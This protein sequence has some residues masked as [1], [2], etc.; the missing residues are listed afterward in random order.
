MVEAERVLLFLKS[1]TC[2]EMC[3]K[4]GV[5]ERSL[6]RAE[7]PSS[8]KDNLIEY[9]ADI[10]KFVSSEEYKISTKIFVCLFPTISRDENNQVTQAIWLLINV[11]GFGGDKN[12]L[13]SFHQTQ[14]LD[15][16]P[17]VGVA[18]ATG[19]R[20][21]ACCGRWV[22]E[23]DDND[24]S[25]TFNSIS[26][27]FKQPFIVDPSF[28]LDISTGQIFCFLPT[29]LKSKFP[30]HLHGYFSLSSNRRALAWPAHDNES[31]VGAKWNF[32]LSKCIG[33]IAYSVFLF[34]CTKALKHPSPLDY[35]YQLLSCWSA[36][37]PDNTL[38][39]TIL[40]G[41][42]HRLSNHL[43]LYCEQGGGK[44]ISV[45]DGVF[46]P[47]MLGETLVHEDTC[48]NLLQT[49]DQ[50]VI[51]IPGFIREIV[52][53]LPKFKS[54]IISRKITPILIRNLLRDNWGSE[55][56]QRYLSSRDNSVALL[57]VVLS[58]LS[59]NDSPKRVLS[60]LEG[61]PLLLTSGCELPKAFSCNARG[62]FISSN[63]PALL[64]IFPGLEN[65]FVDPFLPRSIHTVLLSLASRVDRLNI[66]D[67][68][69]LHNNA[70]MFSH[71]LQKCM[72]S[73]FSIDTNITSVIWTPLQNNQPPAEWI[74]SLFEFIGSSKPILSAISHLPI[75]PQGLLTDDVITLL[76]LKS[77]IIYI[78]V[79]GN[80]SM[81][82]LENLL[83]VSGCFL[84]H[85]HTFIQGY[86]NFVLPPVP[87]GLFTALNSPHILDS[88]ITA[89]EE[90][91]EKLKFELIEL[92]IPLINKQNIHLV[93]QLPL[94]PNSSSEWLRINPGVILPPL[95]LPSDIQYPS[96]ILTPSNPNVYRFC[97]KLRIFPDSKDSFI[98]MHLVPFLISLTDPVSR[99][100]LT[101]WILDNVKD[102]NNSSH[103]Y[104][105][106][107][108][109]LLDSSGSE[110][111]SLY[112]PFQLLDPR[113]QLL[114]MILPT[115]SIGYFP[116]QLYE[117][118]L[119]IM[120]K[121]L[122]L[123]TRDNLTL[124]LCLRICRSCVL[125]LQTVTGEEWSVT[126]RAILTLLSTHLGTFDNTSL[127]K[128]W[129]IFITASFIIPDANPPVN[130]PMCL[131]FC[132]SDGFYP[133]QNILV[134][135][136]L[137][138]YLVGSVRY[139]LV[140]PD[141]L[142]Q[143][144]YR[145]VILNM[146]FCTT[147]H[148]DIVIEQL[149]FIS[150]T[151]ILSKHETASIHEMVC[152]IYSFLDEKLFT[153]DSII[154]NFIFI[155]GE[156][157]FVS[158]EQVVTKTPFDTTPYL[159]SLHDLNYSSNTLF[160][161][162]KINRYPTITQLC[163]ILTIL[164]LSD[165]LL[166][167]TQLDLVTN[168]LTYLIRQTTSTTGLQVYVPGKDLK[169]YKPQ[170][171]ELVFCDQSWL[172]RS[173]I[174][175]EFIFVHER[176]PNDTAYKL[177]VF[178]FSEKVALPSEV[179]FEESG[180][181]ILLTDRIRG[182]LDSYHGNINVLKEML[183][184]AD[185]AKATELNVIF[186]MR[187]H[188]TNSL[189]SA[190]LQDWQGPAI[191]FHN[192]STFKDSDFND[193][194]RIEGAT[195]MQDKTTIGRFGLG[196]CTTYHLTDLPSFV[197][198]SYIHI[199][200][201]HKR[202][203]GHQRGGVKIDFCQGRYAKYI[204]LYEDQFAPY[205]DM[206]G[207]DV[208][209]LSPF[210]GTL[211]RLPFR[212]KNIS[213]K[214][215]LSAYDSDG[216]VQLQESFIR[217]AETLLFFTQHVNS[218]GIYVINPNDTPQHMNLIHSVRRK[219]VSSPLSIQPFLQTHQQLIE[220][221]LNGSSE[222]AAVSTCRYQLSVTHKADTNWIVS[223]ATGSGACVEVLKKFIR[224]H[225]PPPFAGV[226]YNSDLAAQ[227]P[228]KG[229]Q[230]NLY[231]FL[232]LPI[233]IGLPFHCHAMFEL[234]SDRQGLVEVAEA[235]TEWN[236]VVVSDALVSA[237]LE[238]YQQLADEVR[239]SENENNY[240]TYLSL[241][242]NAFSKDMVNDSLWTGFTQTFSRLIERL[243]EIFLSDSR[244]GYVWGSFIDVSFLNI[245]S[246]ETE[247]REFYS[248][249][250]VTK[251]RSVLVRSGY[252]VAV[253]PESSYK[254]SGLLQYILEH[255][256]SNIINLTRFASIFFANLTEHDVS[257]I[258]YILNI[259]ISACGPYPWLQDMLRSS[260]CIPCGDMDT[261]QAPGNVVD[262]NNRIIAQLYEYSENRIP[263]EL[264]NQKLFK[265]PSPSLTN[266]KKYLHILSF[267]LPETELV[268]R[269]EYI[270][271]N[272]NHG[273]A[274]NFIEYLDQKSFTG[275]EIEEMYSCLKN[276]PFI[277]VECFINYI[278]DVKLEFIA[279]SQII[280]NSLKQLVEFQYPVVPEWMMKYTNFLVYMKVSENSLHLDLPMIAIAE[281]DICIR[282]SEIMQ[283]II[284]MNSKI[285]KIYQTVGKY[286]STD[287]SQ[288]SQI[289]TNCFWIPSVGFCDVT[290][291]VLSSSEDFSPYIHSLN[292]Y[293]E[294]N[295]STGLYSFFH[296]LR[297]SK[298]LSSTQCQLVMEELS[299]ESK[300][301]ALTAQEQRIT[302]RLIQ[303]LS[304]CD[305]S[306]T[307]MMMLGID[308]RIHLAR[309]C[310]FHDLCW[311]KR[312]YSAGVVTHRQSTYHFIHKEVSHDN[313]SSLG[314]K[315][316]SD[317]TLSTRAALPFEYKSG[318]QSEPLTTRLRSILRDYESDVDVFKELVQN[319]DDAK[320][321]EVKFL[322]DFS[323][324]GSESLITEK[325]KCWQG[326]AIYC[327]NNSTFSDSDF[328]NITKL[329][330]RSKISDTTTIGTFGIGFNTVYHF[331]D[332]PSFVSR[333][334][335]HIFDPHVKYLEGLVPCDRPGMSVNFVEACDDLKVFNDQFSVYNGVFG[336]DIFSKR[337]YGHTLFR[338]PLRT[339]NVSS[340]ISQKYYDTQESIQTL[341]N[342]FIEIAKNLIIFLQNI[343]SIELYERSALN[344][345]VQLVY[346]VTKG[347]KPIRFL[348]D[349]ETHFNRLLSGFTQEPVTQ[350]ECI[351]LT[352]QD[353]S[354][355]LTASEEVLI[356]YSSGIEQCCS[357]ARE[358]R[359]QHEISAK[360]LCSVAIP[361]HFIDLSNED[362]SK[363]KCYLF[364]FLPIPCFSGYPMHINGT[365]QLQ[366]SR[367]ALHSTADANIR[368]RWNQTLITEALSIALVNA[369]VYLTKI[370][371]KQ[372]PHTF[373]QDKLTRYYSFWPDS[374]QNELLWANYSTSV[375]MRIIESKS[376][377]FH[378]TLH[379]ERWV[380]ID[381]VVFFESPK[382]YD[383]EP[384][385]IKF[386][387]SF[388]SECFI[389]FID[390]CP[391]FESHP[392]IQTI[393]QKL[394]HKLYSLR[395]VCEEVIWVNF[396]YFMNSE[397]LSL[398]LILST[399]LPVI[400]HEPWLK[401]QFLNQPC[402]PCGDV[403][404]ILRMIPS[405]VSP[406]SVFSPI[407]YPEDKVIPHNYF[408]SLF[409]DFEY[410]QALEQLNVI[411][412]KLPPHILVERCN[413]ALEISH[414]DQ[415]QA[416]KH[417]NCILDYLNTFRYLTPEIKLILD[418]LMNIPFIPVHQDEVYNVICPGT[419]VFL[420]APSNCYEF[421]R[422]MYLTPEL[423]AVTQETN[424]LRSAMSLLDI[425]DKE[426]PLKVLLDVILNF[427]RNEAN[428]CNFE[429]SR[430]SERMEAVYLLIANKCFLSQG[431][432]DNATVK[433]NRELV[434][435][436]LKGVSWIWHQAFCKFFPVNQIYLSDE[437]L[438][439]R[440]RYLIHFPYPQLIEKQ[441]VDKFFQF[442]G[443]SYKVTAENAVNIISRM[444]NDF[445]EFPL[446]LRN[447]PKEP[448]ECGLVIHLINSLA[449]E[450]DERELYHD[451]YILTENCNLKLASQLHSN[452]MPWCDFGEDDR[453]TLVHSKIT[454][455]A[456][457]KLG[458]KSKMETMYQIKWTNFGQHE[459]LTN[460]IEGL[461]REFPCDV[462]IFKEL[463]QNAEDA[464]ATEVVFVLDSRRYGE[465]TLCLSPNLQKNWK[466]LQRIPSLL[467]YNNRPFS[468]QDFAGIQ[469]VGIGGKRGKS[470]IGRF[471]LGFNSVYHLTRCPCLFVGS[472][473]G[474]TSTFCVFDPYKEH[475]NIPDGKLPGFKLEADTSNLAMFEDQLTPYLQETICSRFQDVFQN[476]RENRS[477]SMF[478]LP[479]NSIKENGLNIDDNV[480]LTKKLLEDLI[481]EAPR[482]FPFIKNLKN[483]QIY[484]VTEGNVV[485]NAIISSQILQ[486]RH[487]T[488][489]R[490]L[491]G[492]KDEIEVI[493][494]KI[495]VKELVLGIEGKFA[496]FTREVEWLIYHFNGDVNTFFKKSKVLKKYKSVYQREKLV[497]FS[498]IAVEIVCEDFPNPS[499]S[500]YLFCHLPFGNALDFPVHVNAPF[501]LDANRRYVSYQ[502]QLTGENSW[503]NIWHTEI[504]KLILTPLYFQLLLDLGSGGQ[505]HCN[506]S[507][508]K[509]YVWYYKLFPVI[510]NTDQASNSIEFLQ[511]L[512][513]GVL[514]LLY[515][516]NSKIL[517]ADD[518][519]QIEPRVWFPIQG[520]AAGI[521]KAPDSF[522]NR[523]L[524]SDELYSCLVK[525]RYPLTAAP[526]VIAQSLRAS[527]PGETGKSRCKCV[528]PPDV[529]NFMNFQLENFSQG[530]GSVFPCPM[531]K[532]VLSFEEIC[533]LLTYVFKHFDE[534]NIVSGSLPLKVDCSN[535]L[536]KFKISKTSTFT[537]TYS[538]LLPH[539]KGR[540]LSERYPPDIVTK[541][542][543]YG[544][545]EKMNAQF[546]SKKLK[547]PFPVT[548]EFFLLF[549]NFI[550]NE[551]HDYQ[552]F[553]TLFGHF[554]LVSIQY[555]RDIS[556][557]PIFF[558]IDQLKYI[559]TD[560]ISGAHRS[561][562]VNLNCPFLC[563][564]ML[565]E[566]EESPD[567]EIRNVMAIRNLIQRLA[568]TSTAAVQTIKCISL[569]KNK[570][571]VLLDE[572][573]VLLRKLLPSVECTDLNGEDYES[574]SHLRIFMSES[575]HEP[576]QYQQIA[577]DDYNMYFMDNT[578]PYCQELYSLLRERYGLVSLSADLHNNNPIT[579]I[580]YICGRIGKQLLPITTVIQEYILNTEIF[581]QMCFQEQ[582]RIIDY[583]S[584]RID[585]ESGL[586]KLE[587]I[588][589]IYLKEVE[590]FYFKP[591]N[592]FSPHI[593]FFST[594]QN[595]YL[596][597]VE[598]AKAN[599]LYDTMLNLGL[600]TT[601][602]LPFITEAAVAVAED[603]MNMYV[604]EQIILLFTT[605]R[606]CLSE[607]L[608]N[609]IT[610]SDILCLQQLSQIPF[611]PMYTVR[612]F[613]P[614]E[615]DTDCDWRL[616]YFHEAQMSKHSNYCCAVSPI[617]HSSI[618]FTPP[619]IDQRNLFHDIMEL[620]KIKLEPDILE[621]KGN[622][623][624]LIR[625]FNDYEKHQ[626]ADFVKQYF[627][628]TYAYLEKYCEDLSEFENA[629]CILYRSQ[630]YEP[631]N[632]V[633]KKMKYTYFPYLFQCQRE[634]F[635]YTKVLVLLK[636]K[637]YPNFASFNLVLT[638]IKNIIGDGNLD[639][640]SQEKRTIA[641]RAFSSLIKELREITEEEETV[642]M[643][644]DP[645]FWML[646]TYDELI[647]HDSPDLYY[648]DDHSLLHCVS[649]CVSVRIHVLAPL[650]WEKLHS[651]APPSCLRMK[652]LTSRFNQHL[653]PDVYQKYLV[654]DDDLEARFR[655]RIRDPF[656]L[657][658]L[659]RIYY[660]FMSDEADTP[661]YQTIQEKLSKLKIIAVDKIVIV[662]TDERDYQIP[663]SEDLICFLDKN[664][665]TILFKE[666][667]NCRECVPVEV[668]VVLNQYFERMFDK[669]L[670]YLEICLVY[671]PEQVSAILDS[672]NIRPHHSP[673]DAD[674]QD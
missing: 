207:C 572:E 95:N 91:D 482:L 584:S 235:K 323:T 10:N 290:R 11:I 216:I 188:P 136:P 585:R 59:S 172:N 398:K 378:C 437:Y 337:E 369:L 359:E 138:L 546:L 191:L 96:H 145:K 371:S 262:P 493:T 571:A 624:A 467:V 215:S 616:G 582:I 71:L 326:P 352:T 107:A 390:I 472:E 127:V 267:K 113:D 134:C 253:I 265:D 468:Q 60:F 121:F 23:W 355:D 644:A 638:C 450:L 2:I 221:I 246:F 530:S 112:S 393:Y 478:R 354:V 431:I 342:E 299:L 473:D 379:P 47:S 412:T 458:A 591:S 151:E 613:V 389:Y 73:L 539:L 211:F 661:P 532:C 85:K 99:N 619:P 53:S 336:C 35:H 386:I 9:R 499:Q 297:V 26:E 396:P 403:D 462:T 146:G 363:I 573:A 171:E 258:L 600:N 300:D 361:T 395:R 29:Q 439:Y 346:R 524:Y 564:P 231:C 120:K 423:H 100:K 415:Q 49:F 289:P 459:D 159:Y 544:Y 345:D 505:R 674:V 508:E 117:D 557:Q 521:F 135:R 79:S 140:L 576:S 175:E 245:T 7:V 169:L 308:N 525:L 372:Y 276:T 318:G 645:Q 575:E 160:E 243:P 54:Q 291:L 606:D 481:Q 201:P 581:P 663:N 302:L 157:K 209:S 128:I 162:M 108:K 199:L 531:D 247:L 182:I 154:P 668:T 229:Y 433:E 553:E 311:D 596:L 429:D 236:R 641:K 491:A 455:L 344:R 41:G 44:W 456:S 261:L 451:V 651:S 92:F 24:S 195:K 506:I 630:L 622:L 479:L 249:D 353:V 51:F 465:E 612:N 457:H 132:K 63:T 404:P 471:G 105:M 494:K 156:C 177:G 131:P 14:H 556:E 264:C 388:A 350:V 498:S 489:M 19:V 241:L 50:P 143:A 65:D 168:I 61:V 602:T 185:D 141:L 187:Y 438:Q 375:C 367:R 523:L 217:E 260:L 490:P 223:F 631:Q 333:N 101:T 144:S 294:I 214:I 192:N 180:Q 184:N 611:I 98:H 409:E 434:K 335:L 348:S 655:T 501:I 155:P 80:E 416:L 444:K 515:D 492:Y 298:S 252:L 526:F 36:H 411:T 485:C 272:S 242:F 174:E 356:S 202:Y 442:M 42:L 603:R 152:G 565:D 368:T 470:T 237:A 587:Q 550:V 239:C 547:V 268:A 667:P 304:S 658:A 538:G 543:S 514:N 405:V 660:H 420:S 343:E 500:K 325:M 263:T 464:G 608:I 664:E 555:G 142:D 122:R 387:F 206:F 502:D 454:L 421:S 401:L 224:G 484:E 332:L 659:V 234:R 586:C 673:S 93:K 97:E 487:S 39:S 77:S 270:H 126:F 124:D 512:G 578:F 648:S 397:I 228:T 653:S 522:H 255:D 330:A 654:K 428:L 377:V 27:I 385:L 328:V 273:L 205:K 57:E 67:V 70:R 208:R 627:D 414:R 58:A 166:S 8:F 281:L 417:V 102:L 266:L 635:P 133:P 306:E 511:L 365:F 486:Q 271:E 649:Q 74:I 461:L 632:I 319:S 21:V 621:V 574:L 570:R 38:F 109:W 626:I 197:S 106:K 598:W 278:G 639:F 527:L 633:L 516:T 317:V 279:P 189:L 83:E 364:C 194:M 312:D 75:L 190:S 130:W 254:Y 634:L 13:F 628:A 347:P 150:N 111:A 373:P 402:M 488:V 469:D 82:R 483:I 89:L 301:R 383:L 68:T 334:L 636:V 329:A 407:F 62:T 4:M 153:C 560:S 580:S 84:C 605:L 238:L 445:A 227:M 250:F 66:C 148:T 165:S 460:R 509:Y 45:S 34:I 554:P 292:L 518:V 173:L 116:N 427:Q 419:S 380:S 282:H 535:V 529:L 593:L 164:H 193:I 382:R 510:G 665:D 374:N 394:P 447:H 293:Y 114:T 213:S 338:L 37:E 198:R 583:L 285:T 642:L 16:L 257:T 327:Y 324:H 567:S 432:V 341:Q 251:L 609:G 540:F 339:S 259:L 176:I 248:E 186:D 558:T 256:N 17:W 533:T 601:V 443:I 90:S 28:S 536:G 275:S 81:S 391:G 392:I 495:T 179:M 618:V 69:D 504:T 370:F 46:P 406:T 422:S 592:L 283:S 310:V 218:L 466:Q 87:A 118:Y 476:L 40:C 513:R 507:P 615:A 637:E 376:P 161:C 440:S 203:I 25:K 477:F 549:W 280:A 569:A 20:D 351:H 528:S 170:H 196:F 620:L 52:L 115:D 158:K 358:I 381:E 139:T 129:N 418:T 55:L 640:C 534:T 309:E 623:D 475:L 64:K 400:K 322:V 340:D 204:Q 497:L 559:A 650:E 32:M 545:V 274:I 314:V 474:L 561:A 563:F 425:S 360:P 210:N 233:Q 424:S 552:I 671:P 577:L 453:S 588:P 657:Q 366:Q 670:I 568:I 212:T 12:E 5:I 349:N 589:F 200:D 240:S 147:I 672:H 178:P 76:P 519:N 426:V 520:N 399:L 315:P 446:P 566:F 480:R 1:V 496:W 435:N 125:R 33:T 321:T 452:D 562:L 313:A 296:S 104:L 48:L 303:E 123:R 225:A 43:L 286:F 320:A 662:T 384:D 541:L 230:S 220:R 269:A 595:M 6:F 149:N 31:D 517:L 15:H 604:I 449:E 94:F 72:S 103:N 163:S 410:S 284:D 3:E 78:E 551:F 408:H 362:F 597:P 307:G 219:N 652:P 448:D 594:F 548:Q 614:T 430:I 610:Q 357:L 590:P 226:A 22:F 88:F 643:Q 167:D 647:P 629:N 56:C 656:V 503:D 625:C 183:Q 244:S 436:T 413:L 287:P 331:T 542:M 18:L 30:F 288:I 617:M 463:L 137:E 110:C 607:L 232:P 277:P 295:P 579:L 646:T 119:D 666:D 537:N 599:R 305:R 86:S 441:N 222:T 669:C 181:Q 316:L